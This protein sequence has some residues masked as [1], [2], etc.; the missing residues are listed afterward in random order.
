MILP[1]SNP[2]PSTRFDPFLQHTQ[3]AER[4][5][6]LDGIRRALYALDGKEV[7]VAGPSGVH[8]GRIRGARLVVQGACALA[9]GQTIALSDHSGL[10][11]VGYKA[12]VTACRL[13]GPT[14]IATLADPCLAVF[15]PGR[16]HPRIPNT[17]DAQIV[18]EWAEQL[19]PAET[20]DLSIC[21]LGLLVPELT[22]MQPGA[23]V[24][25]HIRF[26]DRVIALDAKIRTSRRVG[27]G[28][29]I[30]VMF[31]T[32]S[33]ELERRIGWHFEVRH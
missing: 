5:M 22:Q 27:R 13:D 32:P 23:E 25:T 19:V 33:T 3:G 28:R 9:V 6:D 11:Y 4:A 16:R 2:T 20:I 14:T 24:M 1:F 15:F 17:L 30:G 29:R 26:P 21:G 7:M 12:R 10:R 31:L 8:L 18:V